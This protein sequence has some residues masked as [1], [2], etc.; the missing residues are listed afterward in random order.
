MWKTAKPVLRGL[1]ATSVKGRKERQVLEATLEDVKRERRESFVVPKLVNATKDLA[2]IQLEDDCG[3]S[4][5][6]WARTVVLGE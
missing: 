1:G 6:R 4:P 3:P 2:R 5:T